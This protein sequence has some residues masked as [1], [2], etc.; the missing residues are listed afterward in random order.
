MNNGNKDANHDN[1]SK[2]STIQAQSNDMTKAASRNHVERSMLN[3]MQRIWSSVLTRSWNRIKK[4][5][6]RLWQQCSGNQH[7]RHAGSQ[8]SRLL[9]HKQVRPGDQSGYLKGTIESFVGHSSMGLLCPPAVEVLHLCRCSTQTHVVFIYIYIYV[10]WCVCV[11]ACVFDSNVLYNIVHSG[12]VSGIVM[13]ISPFQC[14][15][16]VARR[17]VLCQLHPAATLQL[18]H[19]LTWGLPGPWDHGCSWNK[20]SRKSI[21]H[22]RC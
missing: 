15:S 6:T 18:E 4:L 13:Q 7:I 21:E 19:P 12:I 3:L 8:L 5:N 16:S 2:N 17:Q 20:G 11:C 22:W 10:C 14:I 1:T 9:W